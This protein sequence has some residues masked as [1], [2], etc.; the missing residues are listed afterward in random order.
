MGIL[1]KFFYFFLLLTFAY[2]P[3]KAQVY[4]DLSEDTS[5]STD[6]KQGAVKKKTTTRKKYKKVKKIK[7]TVPKKNAKAKKAKTKNNAE[8][9]LHVYKVKSDDV[10]NNTSEETAEIQDR[11]LKKENATTVVNKQPINTVY[12]TNKYATDKSAKSKK[13]SLIGKKIKYITPNG[14]QENTHM[15][16]GAALSIKK[17][18][19]YF[20]IIE[21]DASCKESLV[22]ELVQAKLSEYKERDNPSKIIQKNLTN[23]IS[24]KY[25]YIDDRQTRKYHAYLCAGAKTLELILYNASDTLF[26]EALTSLQ[27]VEDKTEYTDG[28]PRMSHGNY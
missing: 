14:W 25:F 3:V 9:E 19:S 13:N 4:L 18:S 21:K 22:L 11:N 23:G 26:N 5:V 10:Q 6:N 2:L 8:E 27:M 12:Q 28:I 17:G 1:M 15:G 24:G 16:K 7:K 20:V